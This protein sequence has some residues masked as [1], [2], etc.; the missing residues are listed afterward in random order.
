MLNR[1]DVLALFARQHW[2]ASVRQLEALGV[3][4]SSIT[5]ACRSGSLRRMYR[6]VV[7]IAAA[8]LPFEGEALAL[9]L[10]AGETAFVSGP[11]A[12]LLHG[13]RGMPASPIEV[14]IQEARRAKIPAPHR[15][16]RTSW[17]IQSRDVLHRDDGLIVASPLRMLFGLAE[18]FSQYRFERAAE[19]AWHRGLVTPED[20]GR[21]LTS[22]RQSGKTG[23][24]RMEQWLE[25]TSF[26]RPA[27]SGLELAF[28]EMI[29]RVGL[30]RPVRQLPLTLRSGETIHLDLAWPRVRLAVEPGHSWWH[31]GDLRQRADQARDRACALLGWHV[32]RYDE[33]AA[34]DRGATARELLALYR[35]REA[36]LLGAAGSS[37]FWVR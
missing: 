25:R 27:Q 28:V 29:E 22:I 13:L 7:A 35:R 26:T 14:T 5:R 1:H 33:D 20:A 23:V 3:E 16:V 11:S 17:I 8:Q 34:R 10:T 30:P 12:G 32:L 37:E 4:T 6:G 19:D 9:Q 2:V 24:I 15:L 21:Y 31:G 18:Q 36:D